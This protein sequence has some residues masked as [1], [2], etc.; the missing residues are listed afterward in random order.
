[1]TAQQILA[2][3]A[4]ADAVRLG[5][6]LAVIVYSLVGIRRAGYRLRYGIVLPIGVLMLVGAI[7]RI[8]TDTDLGWLNVLSALITVLV[9]LGVF[10]GY[11]VLAVFLL[12]NGVTVIRK[13][14]RRPSTMLSLAAGLWMVLL[15][16]LPVLILSLTG[17][18]LSE[19]VVTA[20]MGLYTLAFLSTAY[21]AFFFLGFL[22]S[23]I[24]YRRLSPR[25]H[26][27]YIVILG[28]GLNGTEP[29]PL[30]AGRIDR[31][32]EAYRREKAEG[33]H[34]IL[35]PSGGQGPDEVISEAEAM[36]G[37]LLRQ[38]VPAEDVLMEDKST[39]TMENLLFS[40]E[41]M[42]DPRSPV[43]VAT[44]DYHVYRAAMFLRKA[45]LR[46]R[47]VGSKTAGYYVPSAFLR[48]YAA[49]LVTNKVAHALTL[50]PVLL[51]VAA[52]FVMLS[53]AMGNSPAS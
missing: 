46:G 51:L 33:R 28:A 45:G 6:A 49:V 10:L 42:A 2:S 44:S 12:I 40:K 47:V 7:N 31:G 22:I 13:E 50:G 20:L 25:F 53:I 5:A 36:R 29:T 30:L 52:L 15:P 18:W 39:T 26:P 32:L 41:L 1:M 3:P 9:M 48:E 38:G 21:V 34:P 43:Y 27:A 4:L 19:V 37:Y 17:G 14:G 16:V 35:L 11:L 24:G 8:V 23:A